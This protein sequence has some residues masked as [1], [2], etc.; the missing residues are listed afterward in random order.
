MSEIYLD[1]AATT[2]VR[3]EVLEAISPV[4]AATFGN[5]SGAHHVAR[6]ARRLLDDARDAVAAACGART[7]RTVFTAG[8]T[9]A[10]N[11][12]ICGAVEAAGSAAPVIVTTEIEHKAVLAAA[13]RA[14]ERNGGE[15]RLVGVDRQG[16]VDLDEL[17][18]AALGATVVSVMAA[19]NEVGT[20]QPLAEVV[21]RVRAVAPTAVLHTDAVQAAPWY[22]LAEMT[23]GFDLVSISGH[24]LGGLKGTGA[25]VLRSDVAL[26]AQVVGG[27]QER[28]LRAGTQDVAGAVALATALA[29]CQAERS[30]ASAQVAARRERFLAALAATGRAQATVRG[31][32]VL[33]GHA[34][35]CFDG[36]LTE[37]L[38]FGFDR[39][40][41]AASGGSSCQSGALEASHVVVAMG[42]PPAAAAGAVRF[43]LGHHTTDAELDEAVGIIG[44]VCDRLVG[45]GA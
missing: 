44:R 7:G 22:D 30:D 19:N 8:G 10:D 21:E 3:P 4:L 39:E 38:L 27:S 14:A 25:L 33:P 36:L 20:V 5:P 6:A 45:R 11:L 26:S 16:V 37:E 31:V 9:E 15:V 23:S 40:G 18:R 28:G 34:H 12:A 2:A 41:L 13:A 43:T 42:C 29:A 32:E 35:V 1:H 17:S 24:K